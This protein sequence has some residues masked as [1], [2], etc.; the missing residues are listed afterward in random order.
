MISNQYVAGFFDG[1]GWVT[2]SEVKGYLREGSTRHTPSFRAAVGFANNHRG[3]LEQIGKKFGG[4]I[5]RREP[6]FYVLNIR[7]D[8]R[9]RI[10]KAMMP[11]LVVKQRQA[12]LALQLLATFRPRG[13]RN[14]HYPLTETE[15]AYRRAIASKMQ[16][17][18]AASGH[19]KGRLSAI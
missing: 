14:R 2:V 17:V 3:V 4:T 8:N 1:D 16:T 13:K 9:K 7:G 5:Y 6:R 11:H 18:N 19:R 15:L 10:L 12:G